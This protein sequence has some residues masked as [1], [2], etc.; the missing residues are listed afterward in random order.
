[1][2]EPIPRSLQASRKAKVGDDVAV[3]AP[4][5]RE[6]A[7]AHTGVRRP[8]GQVS[9]R[10]RW[11]HGKRSAAAVQRRAAGAAGRK[12]AAWALALIGTPAR[13]RPRPIRPDQLRHFDRDELAMLAW[14]AVPGMTLP[15]S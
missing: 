14:L 4:G 11:V 5:Q 15:A 8:G 10:N 3:C 1:M 6:T 13:V 7:P 2:T 9:N 12:V